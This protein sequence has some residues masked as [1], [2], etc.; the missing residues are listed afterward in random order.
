MC[1]EACLGSMSFKA[2]AVAE[3]P[4]SGDQTVRPGANGALEVHAT[5]ADTLD[6]R[7]WIFGFG[8]MVEVLAPQSLRDE[9]K[10]RIKAL[11]KM[12]VK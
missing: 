6:L 3:T 8:E 7:G 11:S 4:L 10:R 5:V 2:E 12:Y 1:Y 9:F